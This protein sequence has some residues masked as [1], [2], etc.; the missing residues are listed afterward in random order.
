MLRPAILTAG[1]TILAIFAVAGALLSIRASL[2]AGEPATPAGK[3]SDKAAVGGITR[4]EF[5]ATI[6]V[7]PT[8]N[9]VWSG[10]LAAPNADKTDGPL[11]TPAAARDAVRKLKVGGKLPGQ[12]LV[13]FRGGTYFLKEPLVFTPE[14]SGLKQAP[15][16]YRAFPRETPVLS[17]GRLIT[18]FK[19]GE[20][21]RWTAEVPDV[22]NGK[23][24]FRQLFVNGERRERSRLPKEGF[25]TVAKADFK[26]NW[27]AGADRFGYAEGDIKAAWVNPTDIEVVVLHF[28]TD[29][30]L[31]VASID[32]ATRTVTFTKKTTKR[33]SDDYNDQ[34]ARYYVENVFEALRPGQWYLDRKAGLLHYIPLPG[35]DMEKAEVIAPRLD[36][37]VRFDGDP[38]A[39]RFV[40]SIEI[41][42]LTFS[43]TEWDLPAGKAGDHQA[44]VDVPGTIRARGAKDIIIE[45]CVINH[46]ATYGVDIAEGCDGWNISENEIADMGGGGVKLNGGG[47]E[48]K[49]DLQT[50]DII[51]QYNRIH[52]CGKLWPSA[53]GILSRNSAK[54]SPPRYSVWVA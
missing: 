2:S 52:D 20:G 21:G 13:M 40:E 51:I 54:N 23:W 14:D 25:F 53:C 42:G 16:G 34:G 43:H 45:N 38:G 19:K 35:E 26:G 6:Y 10:K 41:S 32:E 3:A 22:K 44:A 11:A 37:L 48:S 36:C 27:Q 7:S 5:A 33:L 30:H 12:V 47:A 9:D 46:G 31:P 17:G 49:R 15:I 4:V 1:P 24:R 50:G 18:G 29:A 28:W 8:G 39:G